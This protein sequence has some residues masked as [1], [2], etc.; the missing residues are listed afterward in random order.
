VK[1]KRIEIITILQGLNVV[2]WLW[3]AKFKLVNAYI[4]FALMVY[5]GLLGGASYVNVYYLI[6]NDRV[7]NKK[8]RELAV[9]MTAIGVTLG[10]TLASVCILGLNFTFLK[11][12]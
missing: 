2:L 12:A 5:V 6:L 1:I 4:Q 3:I 11:N 7:M 9:N 8:D 10:I